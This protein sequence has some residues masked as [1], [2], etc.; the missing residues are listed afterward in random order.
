MTTRREALHLYRDIL[1]AAQFF[2]YPNER[3]ELWRDT[4]IRSAREE[5]ESN[6]FLTDPE[7]VTR[8]IVNGRSALDDAVEVGR[9]NL[10][11][12]YPHNIVDDYLSRLFSR[13]A[14]TTASS[15]ASLA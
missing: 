7:A 15:T 3:G 6:K 1:R 14:R 11:A 9:A 2:S 8:L 5:F 10:S 4:I 12:G 13:T